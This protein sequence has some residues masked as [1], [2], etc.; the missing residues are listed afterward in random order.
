MQVQ[1]FAVEAQVYSP[2]AADALAAIWEDGI[3]L[4]FACWR[5]VLDEAELL[6]IAVAPICR[7]KGLGKRLLSQLIALWQ[8]QALKIIFL[9]VREHN[10]IAQSVY[11]HCGFREIGRRHAYYP[12]LRNE[13]ERE[14]AV[15]M[16]KEC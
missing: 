10:L 13:I 14:N 3:L 16:Q 2:Q 15:L 4:A 11:K 7:G 6:A 8:A 9:E 12:P 1:A 5:S